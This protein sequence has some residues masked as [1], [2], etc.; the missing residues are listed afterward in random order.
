MSFAALFVKNHRTAGAKD[1][2][3]RLC[4]CAGRAT[5]THPGL[6]APRGPSRPRSFREHA[7][8]AWEAHARTSAGARENARHTRRRE[9][10]RHGSGSTDTRTPH[11]G[12]ST[13][14]THMEEARTRARPIHRR[15]HR[16]AHTSQAEGTTDA[17]TPHTREGARKR[18]GARMPRTQ[19]G[20]CTPRTQEGART[21]RTR[22]GAQMRAC[23]TGRRDHG[24]AQASHAGRS[25]DARAHTL[26]LTAV[27]RHSRR[28]KPSQQLQEPGGITVSRHKLRQQN[29]HPRQSDRA[30]ARGRS[31]GRGRGTQ[32]HSFF[33]AGVRPPCP[34]LKIKNVS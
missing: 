1:L 20:A 26:E 23:F 6:R 4:D 30:W 15:E 27:H 2:P 29:R 25:T 34:K 11:A 17:R 9:C 16:C 19:K 5:L 28:T 32:T 8:P 3:G 33:Q 22:E 24:R 18:G 10:A 7:P 12:G 13:H 14:A 21:P 31:H